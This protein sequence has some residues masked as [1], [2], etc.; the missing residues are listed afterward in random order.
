MSRIYETD[1]YLK[2]L[3]TGITA[4]GID[5][6]GRHWI[7]LEDT[8]FFPEEGGQNADTGIISF[9]GLNGREEV[10]V[11]DGI[12]TGR[13]TCSTVSDSDR[14]SIRYIVSGPVSRG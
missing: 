2:E 3:K 13:N 6:K 14:I 12:I 8:V 10:K 7:E 5:D 9:D 1:S 11:L 4:A